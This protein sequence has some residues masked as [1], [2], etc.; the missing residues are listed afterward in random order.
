MGLPSLLHW[1]GSILAGRIQ[2]P[3]LIWQQQKAIRAFKGTAVRLHRAT[4]RDLLFLRSHREKGRLPVDGVLL[5][6]LPLKRRFVFST[7]PLS[8]M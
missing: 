4:R 2:S 1:R 7:V 6:N 5:N 3:F 8:S